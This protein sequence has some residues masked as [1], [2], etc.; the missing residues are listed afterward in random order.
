M[1][2]GSSR[3]ALRFVVLIGIVSLFADMTYEGARGITE[4]YLAALGASATLVGIV[5]GFG[6]LVGYVL[7]LASGYLADRTQRYWLITIIGYAVNLLAVP[8][9]ALAGHWPSAAF[10]MI[11]ER[12]GK[13]I[14]NPARDAMLSHATAEMGRGWGFGL[15]EALDQTG[16]T[17]GPLL[18]AGVLYFKDG[19]RTA[20]AVLLIP[21]LLALATLV[22]ARALYPKPQSLETITPKL[23]PKGFGRDYW[24]YLAAVSCIALGYA[25][26]PLI[27]YHFE[28]TAGIPTD[29]TAVFYAAAMAVDGLAALLFG[30]W[31]D[32]KGVAVL[33]IAALSSSV[34]APLVFLGGFSTVLAGTVLWG[35][36]MGAQESI[37]RAAVA[38]MTPMDRRGTAYGLF[39]LGF[40]LFWFVGSALMGF[41]YD[42]SLAALIGFSMAIQWIS[43]PLFF[44]SHR[45]HRKL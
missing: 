8:A 10:L 1:N 33:M 29:W 38:A 25:D 17:V 40:G 42:L 39:N 41:L 36:G 27:A 18:V 5:A 3:T 35:I 16:A 7:R 11:L 19:Y 30:Y 31:Y 20:F 14:R 44:A 43:I 9:L 45:L 2:D 37:M 23:E 21:A 4:P 26:Y 15:H 32:R 34:F 22:L 28:K 12:T 13:A 24:V 6:E